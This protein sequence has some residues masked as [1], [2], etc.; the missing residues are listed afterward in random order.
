MKTKTKTRTKK[1][2]KRSTLENCIDCRSKRKFIYSF[3][4]SLRKW[5]LSNMIVDKLV[6][7]LLWISRTANVV[8]TRS[9]WFKL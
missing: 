8:S 7:F 5:G 1:W 9:N 4:L 3:N 6:F 2:R